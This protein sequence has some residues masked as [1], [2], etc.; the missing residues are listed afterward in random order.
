MMHSA[1]TKNANTKAFVFPVPSI[2]VLFLYWRMP[3]P[4]VHSI[5][6]SNED[7]LNL[8]FPHREDQQGAN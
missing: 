4:L 5:H 7:G 6:V 2:S 8:A 3:G 1:A